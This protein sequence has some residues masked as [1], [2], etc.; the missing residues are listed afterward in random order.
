[1]ILDH[2][3]ARLA[4]ASPELGETVASLIGTVKSL[5]RVIVAGAA[6][7]RQLQSGDGIA[8]THRRP[9]DPA[10]LFYTSGTTGRP[11]GATLTHRNLMVASLSYYAD[12]DWVAP[13]DAVLHAAPLTHGS[14]LYGLPHIARAANSVIP[15]SGHF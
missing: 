6:E 9:E 11:K 14:G 12:I 4:I 2:S 1:Y 5:E 7:W 3:G 8:L 13:T 10:W 15:E